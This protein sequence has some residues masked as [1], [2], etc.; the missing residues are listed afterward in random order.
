M[1]EPRAIDRLAADFWTAYTERHP[2]AATSFGERHLDDRVD[3]LSP[4]AKDAAQ[5]RYERLLEDARAAAGTDLD[6]AARVTGLALVDE[7]DR[8]LDTLASNLEDWTVD[9]LEG[10]QVTI[11]NVESFQPVTSVDQG[12]ALATRWRGFGPMLDQHTD[13]LAAGA[14]AGRLAVR[15]PVERVLDALD[16]LLEDRDE[17]WALLAPAHEDHADWPAAEL[18]TFRHDLRESVRL[19]IRPALARLRDLL[20][21]EILPRA[22]P[23]EEPGILHLP[24]G[25]A[26]YRR[27][28]RVHTSLDLEPDALHQTGLGEVAR[29]N[30]ELPRIGRRA[31]GTDDRPEILRRLRSDPALHFRTP[32]EIVASAKGSLA[33]ANAATPAWFGRMPRAAC[34]V[35]EMGEHEAKHSTIAYYR[36]PAPD[37]S[38]PGQFFINTYAPETRPRYEAEALAYHEAVPGHHLQIAIAQELDG[39]PAFRR[40]LGAT[41]FW[42][43][44]GLYTE[45]LSDEMGLY[46]GD[47]DRIGMLSLDAWRACRLVVDTG[48]HALGWT[49]QQAIDFMVDNTALARN[50]IENEVDRYIVW[51]GQALAYKTGQLAMLRLRREAEAALGT[52]FDIRAFH[53]ALLGDGALGLGPLETVVRAKLGF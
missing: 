23:N 11:F 48:I 46:T 14:A 47:V 2:I 12:R 24:G 38:R 6:A 30:D 15:A 16:G 52:G 31:L 51:P 1:T 5:A 44:W 19:A 33:R 34:A 29:I 17:H 43:G 3:D 27:L 41:S 18:G 39:I 25:D 32:A 20:W 28:I 13:N 21:D 53:D 8:E 45:R 4:A 22:R 7:I 10:P 9:P 35:V 40:H 37:G 26:T 42:E 50:N 36:Q 49:R